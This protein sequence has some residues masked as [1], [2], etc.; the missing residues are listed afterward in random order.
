MIY[1]TGANITSMTL[2]SPPEKKPKLAPVL[3][4]TTRQLQ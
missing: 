3:V 4:L 1:D 2:K